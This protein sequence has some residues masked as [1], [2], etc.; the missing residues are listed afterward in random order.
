MGQDSKISSESL[1]T[2]QLNVQISIASSYPRSSIKLETQP[3]CRV[4]STF[5]QTW[6]LWYDP[7]S[8]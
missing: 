4:A 7:F 3:N 8:F 6:N 5:L 2:L 1:G